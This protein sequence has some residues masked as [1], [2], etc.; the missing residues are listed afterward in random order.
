[1]TKKTGFQLYK[2]IKAGYIFLGTQASDQVGFLTQMIS[3]R[4]SKKLNSKIQ[5]FYSYAH[6]RWLSRDFVSFLWL[7]CLK[8]ISRTLQSYKV[9][10][11]WQIT[12]RAGRVNCISQEYK[13][14]LREVILPPHPSRKPVIIVFEVR[15]LFCL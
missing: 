7:Q 10:K 2:H 3:S 4:P 6:S 9:S 14:R 8:K 1:M 11:A 12:R 5:K 13:N 15:H